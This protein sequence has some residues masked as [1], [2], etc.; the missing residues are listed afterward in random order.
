M[1]AICPPL[2]LRNKIFDTPSPSLLLWIE[3]TGNN[4]RI[5]QK[6]V[7]THSLCDFTTILLMDIGYVCKEIHDNS[8]N[9]DVAVLLNSFLYVSLS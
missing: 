9:S 2:L 3:N 8:D 6:D 7:L 4:L 1:L 5:Y